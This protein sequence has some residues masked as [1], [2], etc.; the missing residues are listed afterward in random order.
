V[1]RLRAKIKTATT[2]DMTTQLRHALC[3]W[4]ANAASR[5][6]EARIFV[7]QTKKWSEMCP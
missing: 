6:N 7:E 4:A 1:L 2:E 5:Q 3:C